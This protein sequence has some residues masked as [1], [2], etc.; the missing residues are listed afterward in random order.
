MKVIGQALEQCIITGCTHELD[1]DRIICR[2]HR[3]AIGKGLVAYVYGTY[4][5]YLADPLSRQGFAD[6]QKALRLANAAIA[7]TTE[8]HA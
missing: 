7:K 6:H 2:P 4:E 3:E 5:S 1:P 8:M